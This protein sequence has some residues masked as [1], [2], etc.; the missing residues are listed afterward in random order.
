MLNTGRP[1]RGDA[2]AKFRSNYLDISNEPLYPF[3]YGLSYTHFE[4]A[5]LRISGESL[6]SRG[7]LTVSVEVT[8]TG[9]RTGKEIVQLYIRDV[10]GSISRPMKELKGFEKISLAPGET[11]MVTFTIDEELL[12]FYN[13]DLDW[14]VEPGQFEVLV[15][16]NARD[17]ERLSFEYVGN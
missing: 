6:T 12:K 9:D 10:I 11:Q 15:G 1:H 13:S 2:F 8:N 16:P 3:G 14:V 4:Y 17:L 7:E 5:N